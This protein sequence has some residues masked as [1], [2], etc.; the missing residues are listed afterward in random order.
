[1]RQIP[2]PTCG[3]ARLN[4]ASL[5]VLIGGRSIAEV[6]AMDLRSAAN[7]LS[8]IELST[9]EAKIAAQVLKE[10]DARMKFLL[11]VGLVTVRMLVTRGWCNT[12]RHARGARQ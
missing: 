2:C 9:R 7:F 1:M 12:A 4:P 3:G 8:T 10:I 11:D 6:S 5:S